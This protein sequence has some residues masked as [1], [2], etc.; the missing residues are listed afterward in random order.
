M[1]SFTKRNT[2]L[3]STARSAARVP[4]EGI[5][6]QPRPEKQLAPGL[7]PSPLDGRLTTSTGTSTLDQLLAGHGGLPMGTCLLIEEQGTT[8]FSG[9]LLRY[10]AA[11]G[12]VQGDQVHALGLPPGWQHQ[13]PAVSAPGTK[14]KTGQPA[15]PA[16]AEEKMKIAWRYEALGN[17][18]AAQDRGGGDSS[19]AP[20]CHSF[21][22]SKRLSLSSSSCKGSFL[23]IPTP[24]PPSLGSPHNSSSPFKSIITHL[25][26]KLETSDSNTIHRIIVPSLLLPSICAAECSR[27]TE[28]L[29]FLHGLRALL[30]QYSS[31]V[32]A[33]ITIPT[34]LFPRSSGLVRWIELLSDGVVELI[35]LPA[36]PAAAAA[37]PSSKRGGSGEKAETPQGFLKVHSLPIY[38]EKGGGGAETGHFRENLSFSLSATKGLV[39]KPYSLP[40]MEEEEQAEKAPEKKAKEAANRQVRISKIAGRYLIFDIDDVAYIRREHGICAVLVGTI[41]QAPTQNVFLGLPVELYAEEARLLADKN[42]GYVVDDVADHLSQLALMSPASRKAYLQSIN[43]QRKRAKQVQDETKAQT[44]AKF[45]DR[46]EKAEQKKKLAVPE[47]EEEEDLL[48]TG[49]SM[50]L[51]TSGEQQKQLPK[52]KVVLPAVTPTTSNALITSPNPVPDSELPSPCPLHTYLNARGYFITPGLR[53]GG[54]YS[55]YPGDPFRYHAHFLANSYEWDQKIPMLDLVTSGRLGTAVKKSFLFGAKD[56]RKAAETKAV[57]SSGDEAEASGD[58]RVWSIEW[59]GM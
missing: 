43:V 58:V 42:A 29:Q 50:S 57:D 19:T 52:P 36:T 56:P 5:P 16:A 24:G 26:T 1:S 59:A 47:E 25:R 3:S 53:F 21:D 32:T 15:P 48:Y 33:I 55:V 22:L 11:E 31:Q 46:I 18:N 10:Y 45:K 28:V 51:S 2:V 40:P 39:I 17:N 49:K 8:D 9:V 54:D 14:S 37:P 4:G 23:P 20:F 12:L 35:P 30:R 38:H 27:P 7:R 6:N 34:S 41:P 13:L 44:R